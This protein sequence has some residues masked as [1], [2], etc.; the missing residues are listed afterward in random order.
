MGQGMMTSI[1]VATPLTLHPAAGLWE[2]DRHDPSF[3]P[4]QKSQ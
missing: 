2:A 3:R 4:K 1:G